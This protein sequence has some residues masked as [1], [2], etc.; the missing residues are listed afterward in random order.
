MRIIM[1]RALLLGAL[2]L[3][4]SGCGTKEQETTS[5]LI[6]NARIFDGSGNDAVLGAVRFDGDRIVEVGNLE[7]LDGEHIIDAGGLALAPGFIDTH[8]HH[9]EELEKYR[10]MPGVLSQGVTTIVRGMD[11]SAGD[12]RSVSEF[13]IVFEKAPAAVNVASFSAHNSIRQFVLGEDNRRPGT[14]G[15]IAAMAAL[16]RSDMQAGALGLST[17]LEYE[18]GIYSATEEVIALARV[19]AENNGRY[20]SHLRDEDDRFIEALNEIIRIGRDADIPVHISHIKLADKL[21]WGSTGDI[22]AILDAARADGVDVTADIYPY[23]RWASNLAVLF[24]KRDYSSRETAEYTFERTA[25]AEDILLI[26][27]PANP[28]YEG[29]T[30]AEIAAITERDEVT[31]LLELSQAADDHRRETGEDTG[32]IARSMDNA[33][34]GAF[35]RWPYVNIC[36]DGWHG[37]HPRGYGSFPRVLGKFVREM[38]VLSMPD[39]IYKMTG[40]AADNMGI[41]ERGRIAA[42]YYADLVLFDPDTIIDRA[43]M[44]E[45]MAVSSGIEQV[46]VNGVL[47]FENGQTTAAYSG[48]LLKRAQ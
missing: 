6:V 14:D 26:S 38:G 22:I 41:V 25:S 46:W 23:E 42:G 18:P 31:S 36:S 20:S 34:I 4:V 15:E 11:G 48:Q 5:T 29:M 12:Y 39:A 32:I 19:A 3:T 44:R 33:D 37:G 21:A 10:H 30:V 35:M 2:A 45:P 28:A 43:T 7:A 8:S 47:A 24:P 17:G 13:N 16:V 1:I 9:D 40:L 27:Y